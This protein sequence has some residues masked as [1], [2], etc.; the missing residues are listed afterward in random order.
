MLKLRPKRSSW[1]SLVLNWV[2]I[3][4]F[5]FGVVLLNLLASSTGPH[6]RLNHQP[7]NYEA[8]VEEM[9]KKSSYWVDVA[10][11][12]GYTPED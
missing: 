4:K 2:S 11:T 9:W 12:S 3:L 10:I 8:T 1:L 7:A 5:V 6:N